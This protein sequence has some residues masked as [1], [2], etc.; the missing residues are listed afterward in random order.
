MALPGSSIDQRYWGTPLEGGF[1]SSSGI[2]DNDA[3]SCSVVVAAR[4]GLE[5]FMNY[6]KIFGISYRKATYSGTDMTVYRKLVQMLRRARSATWGVFSESIDV[7]VIAAAGA[8]ENVPQER[9]LDYADRVC[10]V[11]LLGQTFTTDVAT[12][13]S[14]ALGGVHKEVVG[15][16]HTSCR[17]MAC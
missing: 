14:R 8:T 5:W 4:F 16:N 3:M 12:S 6:A 13:G 17:L 1:S 11:L 10:D 9:L 15:R 2:F 7:E